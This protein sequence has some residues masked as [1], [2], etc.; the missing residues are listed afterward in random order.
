MGPVRRIRSP[1]VGPGRTRV[2]EPGGPP[3]CSVVPAAAGS[4]TAASLSASGPNGRWSAGSRTGGATTWTARCS[5]PHLLQMPSMRPKR[6][7]H[8]RVP[9]ATPRGLLRFSAPAWATAPSAATTPGLRWSPAVG[10]SAAACAAVTRRGSMPL[11]HS[12]PG[13]EPFRIGPPGARP[14]PGRSADEAARPGGEGHGRAAPHH[15]PSGSGRSGARRRGTPVPFSTVTSGARTQSPARP[16]PRPR[17][18][19][20]G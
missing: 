3:A 6:A 7:P 19:E 9:V 8:R 18:P 2:R 1:G 4:F 14:P 16:R 10:S 20:E 12:V 15:G 17:A 5:R 11:R 13:P